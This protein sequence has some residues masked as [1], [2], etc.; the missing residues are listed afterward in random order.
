MDM[1]PPG[2]HWHHPQLTINLS[3]NVTL[4]LTSELDPYCKH[5]AIVPVHINE[6]L[7]SNTSSCYRTRPFTLFYFQTHLV[8]ILRQ[9][10]VFTLALEPDHNSNQNPISPIHFHKH[11]TVTLALTFG[12]DQYHEYRLPSCLTVTLQFN[13][14]V[15]LTSERKP[16]CKHKYM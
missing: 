1:N 8:V 11:G 10:L 13:L 15:K 12:K 16:I 3:L 5:C 7:K 9:N 4:I 2:Q 6:Q 14:T